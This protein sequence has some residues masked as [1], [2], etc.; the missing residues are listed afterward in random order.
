MVTTAPHGQTRRLGLERSQPRA[1]SG[2][3]ELPLCL[4]SRGHAPGRACQACGWPS[5]FL[6]LAGFVSLL[7][8]AG[9]PGDPCRPLSSPWE[10]SYW[11][12][13]PQPRA[14]Q[15]GFHLLHFPASM[16]NSNW[17]HLTL[18]W[19]S[20]LLLPAPPRPTQPSPSMAHPIL[21]LGLI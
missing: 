9:A 1:H 14:S 11:S 15:L 19:E 3:S 17:S 8:R 13:G 6:P 18:L 5:L 16:A 20:A 21:S 12:P 10:A 2:A 7:P 4:L